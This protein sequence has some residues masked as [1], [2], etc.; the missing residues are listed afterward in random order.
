MILPH[1]VRNLSS[2][3]D[4]AM[5]VVLGRFLAKNA[6]TGVYKSLIATD[7][8]KTVEKFGWTEDLYF[9]DWDGSTGPLPKTRVG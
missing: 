2:K 1:L 9:K 3:P 8:I 7:P 4:P 5:P 6:Y